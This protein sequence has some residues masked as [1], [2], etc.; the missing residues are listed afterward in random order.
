M[1]LKSIRTAERYVH[2][3]GNDLVEPTNRLSG[4][5]AGLVARNL[6][7]GRKMDN[8]LEIAAFVSSPVLASVDETRSGE[9]EEKL[10]KG[11]QM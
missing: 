11:W 2:L 10:A 8:L 6:T 9:K 5:V 1:G 4:Y 3:S 7:D